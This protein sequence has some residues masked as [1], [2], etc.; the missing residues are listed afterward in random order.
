MTALEKSGFVLFRENEIEQLYY[1]SN[2]WFKINKLNKKL[3]LKTN[4]TEIELTKNI[5]QELLEKIEERK[6]NYD[7]F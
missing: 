1:H 3:T 7:N 4:N 2:L 5:L 6:N